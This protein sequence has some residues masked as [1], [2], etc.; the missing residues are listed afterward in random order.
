MCCPATQPSPLEQA[1]VSETS[2]RWPWEV[3]GSLDLSEVERACA[4]CASDSI[5]APS[6]EP[7]ESWRNNSCSPRVWPQWW[8]GGPAQDAPD[9]PAKVACGSSQ[10]DESRPS[11][12]KTGTFPSW[13]GE[14][15]MA[16][17]HDCGETHASTENHR[18]PRWLESSVLMRVAANR[19]LRPRG[20]RHRPACSRCLDLRAASNHPSQSDPVMQRWTYL[21]CCRLDLIRFHP[22]A[23]FSLTPGVRSRPARMTGSTSPGHPPKRGKAQADRWVP[24]SR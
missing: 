3:V 20:P 18:T 19:L 11:L 13:P 5:R 15:M 6:G 1:E 22:V 23:G 12:D 21:T 17:F 16:K 14:G 8:R 24:S 4:C 10:G 2:T 9:R 7:C